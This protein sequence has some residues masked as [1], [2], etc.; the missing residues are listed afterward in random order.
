ML[1]DFLLFFSVRLKTTDSI[2]CSENKLFNVNLTKS[3][4]PGCGTDAI[5]RTA[6]TTT[7]LLK[8]SK[9]KRKGIEFVCV[10]L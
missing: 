5:D 4:T 2:L 9:E 6:G 10:I 1:Y 3:F 8:L 7:R